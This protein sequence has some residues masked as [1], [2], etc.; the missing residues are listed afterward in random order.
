MPV[1]VSSA[2]TAT[3]SLS[4]D[5]ALERILAKVGRLDPVTTD[6]MDTLGMTLAEDIVADR[7]VPPF[8]NSAMDGYAVF[9]MD[10]ATVPAH[11]RVVGDIAAGGVPDR[12]RRAR[13]RV[14]TGA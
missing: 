14:R 6:L 3:R 9:G 4:V 8:R 12:P 11:L 7:D 10:V 5:E 13:A 1:S 2:R